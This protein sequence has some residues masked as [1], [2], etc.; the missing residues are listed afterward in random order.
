MFQQFIGKFLHWH[1]PPLRHRALFPQFASVC[2]LMDPPSLLIVNIIFE[3]LH[4]GW[5]STNRTY[6]KKLQSQQ[7]HAL[8]YENKFS[9]TQELLKENN[10]LNIYQLKISIESKSMSNVFLS[11]LWRPL[12]LYPTSFPWNNYIVPSF[13]LAK[14]KYII[15]ICTPELWNIIL[16][17]EERHRI[18]CNFWSNYKKLKLLE[19]AIM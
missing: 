11:K 1:E 9:H 5:C 17:I 13:K 6:L 18:A 7:K 10:V 3:C 2:I 4:T 8:F 19:N 14:S 12:H 16:S 15:T